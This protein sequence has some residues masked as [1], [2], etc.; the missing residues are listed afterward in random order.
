[1]VDMRTIALERRFEEILGWDSFFFLTAEDQ[2]H[3]F[4]VFAAHAAPSA[5]LMFTTG[6]AYDEAMGSIGEIPCI[7]PAS[8]E[9]NTRHCWI[10]TVSRWWSTWSKILP[11]GDEPSGW[12]IQLSAPEPASS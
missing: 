9:Q 6:T 10:T 8:I 1:V 3:M 12:L 5:F 4:A 2:R 11:Q 7:M